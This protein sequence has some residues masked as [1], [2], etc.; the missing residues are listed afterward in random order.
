M[1]VTSTRHAACF[2]A[3]RPVVVCRQST[4]SGRTRGAQQISVQ[5]RSIDNTAR[6][7]AARALFLELALLPHTLCLL[8]FALPGIHAL[9]GSYTCKEHNHHS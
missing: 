6:R 4:V 2:C 3:V 7:W 9:P 1:D 5:E 8:S